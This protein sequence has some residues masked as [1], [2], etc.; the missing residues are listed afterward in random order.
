MRG[1]T[2]AAGLRAGRGLKPQRHGVPDR[3]HG[4]AAGLRAG[5]GLKLRGGSW[6]R[7]NEAGSGRSPGRPWIE[8][9]GT[10]AA[11]AKPIRGAAGLRAGRGL[12]PP[13][14][15]KSGGQGQG[16]AGLR[17]GRGLKPG[18]S[19]PP[20]RG[21]ER[22]GRSPGRPW[23]ETGT[24]RSGRRQPPPGA[25]GLR[26]GRGLK[27]PSPDVAASRPSRSGRSPGRPWIETTIRSLASTTPTERPVSG[28][29]V[30]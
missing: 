13:D 5:R 10:S 9:I 14:A 7:A 2:G 11:I 1:R 29:A 18:V 16:A 26:A 17:A 20:L 21:A 22:S 27:P 12:K 28:P 6:L 25:A 23:I 8:T 24:C 15:P 30:D 19:E 4:G 3:L